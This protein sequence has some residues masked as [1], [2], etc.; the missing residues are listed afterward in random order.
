MCE[1]DV[2]DVLD[3]NSPTEDFLLDVTVDYVVEPFELLPVRQAGLWKELQGK[4]RCLS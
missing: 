4:S 3:L 2:M 1:K